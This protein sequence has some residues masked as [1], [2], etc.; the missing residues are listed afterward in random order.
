MM[1][2]LSLALAASPVNAAE[3]GLADAWGGAA[4]PAEWVFVLETALAGKGVADAAREPV[5]KLIEALPEGDRVRVLAMHARTSEALPTRTIA[6]ATRAAVAD[7]VRKLALPSAKSIDLG[8]ALS[9]LLTGLGVADEAVRIV[10]FVGTFCHSPPLGSPWADGGFGCRAIRNF[11]R[12]EASYDTFEARGRVLALLFPVQAGELRPHAGGADELRRLFEPGT[13]VE[14][15]STPFAAWAE[16]LAGGA[17]AGVRVRPLARVEAGTFAPTLEV[18][19]QPTREDPTAELRVKSGLEHLWFDVSSLSV[20]GAR[21][22]SEVRRLAPD[23]T[24]LLAVDVPKP[25]FSVLPRTDTVPL[26]VT[27]TLSGALG[28]A[29]ALRA[30]GATPERD[31]VAVE[32]TLQAARDYGLS[33]TRS[34]GV[35]V[36]GG[37][38]LGAAALVVGRKLQPLRLG[39][40][41]SYRRAGG[42]RQTLAIERLSEAPLVVQP[43]GTLDVGRREDAVVVLLVGRPLW[44]ARA[45]VEI[46]V[47]NAEINTKPAPP[48]RHTIVAGATSLQFLDYRLSWE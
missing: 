3:P 14:A 33:P 16:S 25:P 20:T 6:E 35:F 38:L 22:T 18:V 28:P 29:D 31:A 27:V 8:A 42:P 36:S 43:D 32:V 21:A 1:L 23:G 26:P 5:A 11:D 37:L 46:R 10:V 39:G 48:G 41:F 4:P 17:H 2:S 44:K 45:S 47:P 30:A 13:A 15:P 7:E 24:L 9:E 19:R 34:A 12:L 40:T